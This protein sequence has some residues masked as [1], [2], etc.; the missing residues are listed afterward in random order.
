MKTQVATDR[1][2]NSRG[3]MMTTQPSVLRCAYLGGPEAVWRSPVWGCTC[4]GFAV[5]LTCVFLG[6]CKAHLFWAA[7]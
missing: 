4:A 3:F 1:F 6:L 2:R 5:C 7:L